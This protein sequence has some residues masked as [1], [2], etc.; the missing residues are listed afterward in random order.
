MQKFKIEIL[1]LY[2]RLSNFTIIVSTA[3][4]NLILMA[5]FKAF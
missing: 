3:L 1:C 2:S 4:F 5:V